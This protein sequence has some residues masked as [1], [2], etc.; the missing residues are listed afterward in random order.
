M[1]M[2]SQSCRSAPVDGT[3]PENFQLAEAM[4]AQ[5]IKRNVVLACTGYLGNPPG[6][7]KLPEYLKQCSDPRDCKRGPVGIHSPRAKNY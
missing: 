5:S 7:S 3:G 2:A 4:P 6:S 1:L